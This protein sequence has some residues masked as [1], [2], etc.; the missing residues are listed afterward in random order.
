MSIA[1]QPISPS[2]PEDVAVPTEPI[3]RLSVAQYHA[4]A[5]HGIL[6]ENDPVELL[7]GWLVQKMTK[8]RPH[9]LCTLRARREM[10]R[11]LPAGWHVESQEPITTADSEPEPDV[12]VIRGSED[13]YLDRQPEAAE[14]ALV[15]EIAETSLRTDRGA[16]SVSKN[17]FRES[18][19]EH[20]AKLCSSKRAGP[21]TA[22]VSPT[23]CPLAS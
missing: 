23:P 4:M 10:E 1:A 17:Y 6:D 21:G 11:L 12:A 16:K 13:D 20:E 22:G 7:E 15:I 2:I 14:V 18:D 3:Y 9:S 5:E 8:H 19:G